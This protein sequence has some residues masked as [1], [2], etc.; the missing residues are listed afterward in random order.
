ME[1]NEI[2]EKIKELLAIKLQIPKD[3][4]ETL[5]IFPTPLDELDESL[6]GRAFVEDFEQVVEFKIF[7]DL[8]IEIVDMQYPEF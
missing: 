1:Y 7:P 6:R 4:I 8:N 2:K 3:Y 5:E